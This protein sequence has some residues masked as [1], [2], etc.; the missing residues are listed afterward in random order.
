MLY[1][2]PYTLE[3]RLTPYLC[4][5]RRCEQEGTVLLSEQ[6]LILCITGAALSSKHRSHPLWTHKK[7]K[8]QR[9]FY[10]YVV[11]NSSS[12]TSLVFRSFLG[13]LHFPAFVSGPLLH[14]FI[15]RSCAFPAVLP[16]G[17][18]FPLL[19]LPPYPHQ[20]TKITCS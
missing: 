1:S 9:H 4:P 20:S 7:K 10:G 13:T 12:H 19:H 11:C 15:A 6:F 18:S 3:F 17:K 2:G 5:P 16:L 14:P 8:S